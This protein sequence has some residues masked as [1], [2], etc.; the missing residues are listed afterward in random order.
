MN[1]HYLDHA[2]TTP[3]HPDVLEAMLPYFSLNFGNPSSLHT[4]GRNARQ[5]LTQARDHIAESLHCSPKQIIFTSGG[6][7]SD[8]L[9]LLGIAENL[10]SMG[11]THIITTQVEHHAVLHTC[12]HLEKE[13]FEVTYLPV[14]QYGMVHVSQ[15]LAAIRPTTGLVS[16]MYGNNEVGTVQPIEEIGTVCREHQVIFHVDGVQALGMIPI[17]L[18]SMPVDLV[19]FSAHKINGPK[20]CGLLYCG[21]SIFLDSQMYGGNQERK[22]RPGTENVAAIMGC[23]KAV[24]LATNR[25]A[26]KQQHMTLL[27]QLFVQELNQVL[28]VDGFVINGH[29]K[30]FLP[31]ILNVGFCGIEKATMLMKLDLIGIA[32]SGGSACTSGS[33]ED[34]HVLIAMGIPTDVM[35]SSIRFSFGFDTTEQMIR[36]VVQKIGTIVN[37]LRKS[38]LATDV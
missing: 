14:D 5:A 13:G 2:A 10:K 35:K 1:E 21:S 22:K 6:T 32:A 7:E 33:L 24:Q 20:G 38:K 16:I 8:N 34:S 11:K 3:L 4:Y 9:A 29:P 17:N 27:R 31:H 25:Q 18:G 26:E 12:E 30:N 37:G 15:V 36:D 23:A 19:S 28:G